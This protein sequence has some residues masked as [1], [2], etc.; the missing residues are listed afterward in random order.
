MAKTTAKPEFDQQLVTI[1]RAKRSIGTAIMSLEK[2][3]TLQDQTRAIVY[4]LLF[5]HV[6]LCRELLPKMEDLDEASGIVARA[7]QSAQRMQELAENAA[8][9]TVAETQPGLPPELREELERNL[10]LM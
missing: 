3:R 9:Q 4:E 5:D 8:G 1:N 2:V 6:C 10:N 7:V